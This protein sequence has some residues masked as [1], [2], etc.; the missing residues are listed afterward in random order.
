[1]G[2]RAGEGLAGRPDGERAELRVHARQPGV[3]RREV[4]VER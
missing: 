3:R 2:A 4:R 1:V